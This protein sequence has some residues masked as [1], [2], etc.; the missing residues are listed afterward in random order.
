VRIEVLDIEW[1]TAMVAFDFRVKVQMTFGQL[2]ALAQ[3]LLAL[4]AYLS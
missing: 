4:L 3:L 2:V 1:E